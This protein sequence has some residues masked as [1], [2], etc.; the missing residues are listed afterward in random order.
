MKDIGRNTG[1]TSHNQTE[2]LTILQQQNTLNTKWQNLN[3]TRRIGK[4]TIGEWKITEIAHHSP[5]TH[6][7]TRDQMM[8]FIYAWLVTL[9][10]SDWTPVAD[11]DIRNVRKCECQIFDRQN[12]SCEILRNHEKVDRIMHLVAKL[13]DFCLFHPGFFSFFYNRFY[14]SSHLCQ[15]DSLS[16]SEALI[17]I[18]A[19]LNVYGSVTKHLR[20]SSA[21]CECSPQCLP[22]KAY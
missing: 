2:C 17:G 7:P 12:L 11:A 13:S 10:D 21:S 1:T 9:N 18:L 8:Q 14:L 20:S 6:L 4:S 16:T 19:I 15:A 22:Q 5:T 3:E